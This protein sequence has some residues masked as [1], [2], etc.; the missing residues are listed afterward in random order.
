MNDLI[1]KSVA[2]GLV[3][4]IALYVV[5]YFPPE[6]PGDHHPPHEHV[7]GS[8]GNSSVG[9]GSVIVTATS[10]G[11]LVAPTTRWSAGA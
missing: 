8:T 1:S 6:N 9:S 11:A 7:H 3:A 5:G 4:P 10:T 2:A